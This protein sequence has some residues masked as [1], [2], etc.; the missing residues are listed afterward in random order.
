MLPR[1]YKAMIVDDEPLALAD[2][3]YTASR[4]PALE[5]QWETAGVR[6]TLAVLPSATPDVVFLDI[7]LGAGSGFDLLPHF[8]PA[9]SIIFVTAFEQYA[10]RAFEI[11]ALDYLLKPV[12]EARL[13]EA[14]GRLSTGPVLEKHKAQQLRP[15]DPLFICTRQERQFVPLENILMIRSEGGNYTTFHLNNGNTPVVRA[16]LNHWERRL[17][18]K[19]FVRVHR[20]AIVNL[21][22]VRRFWNEGNGGHF[23]ELANI[24][25]PIRVSRNRVGTLKQILDR[26]SMT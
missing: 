24:D 12:S 6:E 10:V 16:T 7:M 13:H 19:Q 23:V 18:P 25:S 9:T 15:Q 5:V 22:A 17:P 20:T 8:S 1:R 26:R 14:V 11:N 3:K 2:L 4:H 21:H